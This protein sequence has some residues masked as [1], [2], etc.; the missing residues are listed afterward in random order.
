MSLSEYLHY[1]QKSKPW[2]IK[3]KAVILYILYPEPEYES[4]LRPVILFF[5]EQF[6]YKIFI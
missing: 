5:L 6:Y 4:N 3:N 1:V 2:K